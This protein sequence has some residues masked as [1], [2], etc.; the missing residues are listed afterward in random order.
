MRRNKSIASRYL[1]GVQNGTM[2][3][4]QKHKGL[5][6]S[7]SPVRIPALHNVYASH[8]LGRH[9]ASLGG[10]RR[11]TSHVPKA[12]AT[13]VL[14][15]LCGSLT[16]IGS[17][18]SLWPVTRALVRLQLTEPE[19]TQLWMWNWMDQ[20]RQNAEGKGQQCVLHRQSRAMTPFQG[21][22]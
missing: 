15:A 4:V 5:S 1:E 13:F 7:Q 14:P 19:Y 22:K 16:L 17:C 8:S 20:H 12:A 9:M 3:S 6:K 2:H 18:I 21:M 10:R 11:A